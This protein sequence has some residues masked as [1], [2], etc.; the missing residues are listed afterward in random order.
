MSV[1]QYINLL[2]VSVTLIGVAIGRYPVL[3]MNR[4]TIVLVGSALLIFI[5]AISFDQALSSI[6]LN[7]IT[8][9]FCMMIIN[10]N[11]RICGFFDLITQKV[12]RIARTPSQLLILVIFS[13]GILSALFLNDTIV[14]VYTPLVLEITSL[15]GLN[16]I[17]YLIATACAANVGS[18]AT[19]IGNPQNMLIGISSGISF[20]DFTLNLAP[21]ALG[22]LLFVWLV[23]SIVYHKQINNK[24]FFVEP[25]IKIKLYFPLFYKS[26]IAAVIMII[27]LLLDYPIP[28]SALVASSILLVTRRLK[29]ERVFREIDWGLLVFFSGLFVVTASIDTSK[30]GSHLFSLILPLLQSDFA[31]FSIISAVVSNIVSNVPAVL[32]FKPVVPLLQ[33]ANTLWL[34]LAVSTTFAGNLTLLGSVANLIVAESAK[35]RGVKLS[36][37]EYL[38]A[39]IP[40]TV[41]TL[42]F[43]VIWFTLFF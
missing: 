42:L 11:L 19:I 28:L 12:I 34:L 9:L 35:S 10:V 38:K 30:I 22:A 32:L 7:T 16:P 21:V 4:A 37:K 6:D 2:I 15:L 8:L 39:G 3:R 20:L 17:P 31:T 29:P 33:N 40:V 43:S 27:L 14:L 41:L 25:E 1:F 23:V 24:K 36:F 18:A 5:N 13:S 26:M